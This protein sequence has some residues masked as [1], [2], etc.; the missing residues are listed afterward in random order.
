MH[1]KDDNSPR[2]EAVK[3]TGEKTR[4]GNPTAR[5]SVRKGKERKGKE[6]VLGGTHGGFVRRMDGAAYLAN[7]QGGSEAPFR[8]SRSSGSG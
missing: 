5:L 2:H 6:K 4:G 7:G 3:N 1:M 8:L